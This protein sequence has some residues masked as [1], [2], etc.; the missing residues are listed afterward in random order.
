MQTLFNLP[1]N[2]S[3]FRGAKYVDLVSGQFF[4]HSNGAGACQFIRIIKTFKNGKVQ[5]EFKNSNGI[6]KMTV[7]PNQYCDTY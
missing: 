7:E 2:G 3:K 4:S 5:I 1:R 6:H